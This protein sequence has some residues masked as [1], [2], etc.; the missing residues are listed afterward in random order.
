MAEPTELLSQLLNTRTLPL[1]RE[2]VAELEKSHG[3]S[4]QPVGDRENN[5]GQINIGSDPGFALVER[6]TNAID[7]VVEHAAQ[8]ERID[9]KRRAL[10]SNPRQAVERWF[11]IEAGRIRNLTNDD[12]QKLA[13]RITVALFT[14][15]SGRTNPTIWIRDRGIGLTPGQV[16]N[17]ILSLGGSNKIDKPFLA[18]AYGQGGSTTFAFSPDGTTIASRR[19]PACL[20][21]EKDEVAVT[22]VRFR[23][24]D[25]EINKNGRY[26]YLVT[27]ER[28]V[29]ALN[30]AESSDFEPGTS[31]VH[32]NYDLAK[33]SSAM[34]QLTGSLWWLLQNALFDPVLPLWAEDHRSEVTKKDRPERRSI[35]GNHTRLWTDRNSK[36][37]HIDNVQLVLP[38]QEGQSRVIA[39]YWVAAL[40][41][42]G[43]AKAKPIE[44]Y[45]DPYRPVTYT[46]FGQT[47]GFEDQRFVRDRLQLPYLDRYLI[48]Q[49]EL[50]H[51]TAHARRSILSTTRDRLKESQI[52]E[53]LRERLAHALA[54]D[55]ELI[56]LN[57]QRKEALL[58]TYSEAERKKMRERFARLLTNL[59]AG[60]DANAPSKG[61]SETGRRPSGSTSRDPLPPLPTA[62]APTFLRLANTQRPIQ[63]RID[64]AA[65]LR[66]ES[67]A[68]DGYL[69]DHDP[70]ARLLVAVEPESKLAMESRSDFKGG[71]ARVLLRPGSDAKVG[72]E[73]TVDVFL[74]TPN[75][76]SFHDR[77]TYRILT[78]VDHSTSGDSRRGQVKAPEPVPVDRDRWG[79]LGWNETSVAQVEEDGTGSRILVNMDNEHIIRL[80]HVGGYKETGI[81]RMKNSYLLYCAYYAWLQHQA[82][83]RDDHG[84]SGEEFE[85]YMQD[86]LDRAAQTVVSAIAAEGRLV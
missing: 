77:A 69:A 20:D 12:R 65:V 54:E 81:K 35:A 59:M 60:R 39:H 42:D 68:P 47:H 78:Q 16:P 71:R 82:M 22:F 56:R 49:I 63:V 43:S 51:L 21:G 48:V 37:E 27:E 29:P 45:V 31:V 46:F 41:E 84:L 30:V 9:G 55:Q 72:D 25:P 79:A 73:G 67:D 50:D 7:A 5:Y 10:P 13:E 18:G 61:E 52:Y 14:G 80:L 64:R 57:E 62:D 85:R 8:V 34:T 83:E 70:H 40:P 58:S 28:Q 15:S 11:K 53:D 6:V 2:I 19:D 76:G 32:F 66:L 36:L 3:F 38:H 23:D 86:E 4:W 33:Y 1:A 75:N 17:S 74:L 24:L 44:A 26:E